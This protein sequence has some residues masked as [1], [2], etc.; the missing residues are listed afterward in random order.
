MA[1]LADDPEV[2]QLWN[3]FH[4]VVNMTSEELRKWLLTTG[5]GEVAFSPSPE[6]DIP[7][8][9]RA[10][11][12]ILNKRRADLT[13]TDLDV[14]RTI[15]ATVH[16]RLADPRREDDDWRRALMSLGHDPLKPDSQ[17]PDEENLPEPPG[18]ERS[19]EPTE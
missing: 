11:V 4:S 17:R 15:V 16:E 14:M 7:E 19:A 13:H 3:E 1:N 5:S 18:D 8:R 2:Q 6:D 10:I 9:G 12:E